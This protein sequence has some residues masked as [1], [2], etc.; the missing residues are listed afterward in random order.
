MNFNYIYSRYWLGLNKNYCQFLQG[1]K[2]LCNTDR[3]FQTLLFP[4]QK[5]L[6]DQ[7]IAYCSLYNEQF[8]EGVMMA[9]FIE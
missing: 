3:L 9:Y 7:G 2:M 5:C 1:Y 8:V 6:C 4:W